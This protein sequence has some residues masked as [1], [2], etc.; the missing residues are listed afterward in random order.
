MI[1]D[2]NTI[3]TY[4]DA[5]QFLIDRTWRRRLGFCKKALKRALRRADRI[6]VNFATCANCGQVRSQHA[7]GKCLF[8]TTFFAFVAEEAYP[9]PSQKLWTNSHR[10]DVPEFLR[11]L[12]P[13]KPKA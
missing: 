10:R 3:Q 5:C 7:A 9:R 1:Y 12:V 4:N 13:E 2:Y 11:D 6:R 8:D